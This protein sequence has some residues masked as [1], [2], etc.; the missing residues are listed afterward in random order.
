[1]TEFDSLGDDASTAPVDLHGRAATIW[2]DRAARLNTLDAKTV[3]GLHAAID[4]ALAEGVSFVAFRAQG[5]SFCSGLDLSTLESESEGD[6][7]LRIVRAEL[8]VQRVHSLPVTTAAIAEGDLAGAGVDLF[9]ACDHRVVTPEVWFSYPGL[10]FGFLLGTGR[11]TALLGEAATR[12]LLM[13]D[14][15]IGA[16]E[17]VELGLATHCVDADQAEQTL[18]DLRS[19]AG[20]FDAPTIRLARERTR[21]ADDASDLSALVRSIERPGL[22]RRALDYRHHLS[23]MTTT[24]SSL[25]PTARTVERESDVE[26]KSMKLGG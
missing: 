3:A 16:I 2:I 10:A 4:V 9:A 13:H 17:A 8:L 6:I 23:A 14:G 15:R 26:A 25:R 1:M 22:K 12:S 5:S 21:S 24:R 19:L 11:L 18:A 7:A 20:R